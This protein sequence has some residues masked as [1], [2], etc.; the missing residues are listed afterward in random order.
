MA[1][2]DQEVL[3]RVAR[4]EVLARQA[5]GIL[6]GYVGRLRDVRLKGEVDLVTEADQA[7]E[8]LLVSGLLEA[9]PGDCVLGEEGGVAGTPDAPFQWVLDPLDGTTNFVHGLP[10][11]GV[12]VGLVQD[13]VPVAG[14]L[15]V[16][17]LDDLYV[18]VVEQGATRNGEPIRVDVR[19]RL[20]E[21]VVATGFPY[22]RRARAT[23]LVT[24]VARAI[25]Q[26]RA[27]RRCG[28]ASL[29]LMGV[30]SGMF[31][32]FWEEGLAPWDMAAGVALVR[33][34]GGQVTG[35]EGAPFDLHDGR[36]IASNGPLHDALTALVGPGAV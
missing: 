2:P 35:F 26:A 22:D 28:A 29:D 16:P 19:D 7:S 10:H 1:G 3:D 5:G 24:V 18:G 27:V 17:P 25:E 30:A 23:A 6:M 12:S 8:D 31:G 20:D 34:A 32:G 4:G 11:F 14:I 33:A 9:F 13:G 36:I 15:H 21:S